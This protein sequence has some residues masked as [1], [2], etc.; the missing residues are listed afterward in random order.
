M[1]RFG[2]TRNLLNKD[3]VSL[4]C[5]KFNA[6]NVAKEGARSLKSGD[7]SYLTLILTGKDLLLI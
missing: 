6:I 2:N 3:W 1:Y 7:N 5:N 4:S